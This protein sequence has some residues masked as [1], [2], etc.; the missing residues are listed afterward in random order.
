MQELGVAEV[1]GLLLDLLYSFLTM[2]EQNRLMGWHLGV[3]LKTS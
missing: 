3:C 2:E 1:E